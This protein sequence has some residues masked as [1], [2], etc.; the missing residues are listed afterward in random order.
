MAKTGADR[1]FHTS[2]GGRAGLNRDAKFGAGT[3][4]WRASTR[5]RAGMACMRGGILFVPSPATK[6]N[7]HER[8]ARLR[9]R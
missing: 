5:Q 9:R 6:S 8:I 1:R 3:P 4:G 2:C 7:R